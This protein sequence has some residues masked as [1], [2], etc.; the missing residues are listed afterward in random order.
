MLKDKI[1]DLSARFYEQ[2]LA[3]RRYLHQHPELS[4]QEHET[5]AYIKEQL[6][7]L[8][9]PWKSVA[10]TGIVA[11]ISGDTISEKVI[12]LRAD[13]DALPI[14]EQNDVAYRSVNKGVMHACGH[15]VHTA[16]LLGVAHILRAMKGGFSGTVKFLFQPAEEKFPGGSKQMIEDGALEEPKPQFVVG[17]HT[18]PE[19]A[20]GKIGL[21]PGP[22]SAS[23]DEIYIT[24]HGRGGHASQP[25]ST[26]DPVAVMAQIIVSLQ[27]LVSRMAD[28]K[29]P[30]VLSFGKVI[31]NGAN[32][33]IPNDVYMEGTLRTL[34]NDWRK[35][36]HEK[37]VK[38][39]KGIA[40]S[41]GASCQI[42]IQGFP[43]IV[44]DE[45]F[46][47][48]VKALAIEYLGEE[49]VV[50]L[51]YWMAGED[52]GEFANKAKGCY[53]RLGVGNPEKGITAALHHPNF[54]IDE[55]PVFSMSSGL[56]A[57]LAL[58]KL[59]NN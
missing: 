34:D 21:K 55:Q 49:N 53:Y 45:P 38:M 48:E 52:F 30:T 57:Y 28:P 32:N 1:K 14:E 59:G 51:D 54:D 8:D 42:K 41:M 5:S 43:N 35:I 2:V 46:S 27:Q 11:T 39:A 44:N 19:L 12:A 7:K 22:Y 17:Q 3:D 10:N 36:A 6:D 25:Q 56:M 18:M 40:E 24:I 31:A 13:I 29:T 16:S 23:N 37:I 50:D 33:I 20:A 9:I 15:D 4:F 58:R 47:E 26:I